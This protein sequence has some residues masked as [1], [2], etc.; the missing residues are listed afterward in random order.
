MLDYFS[1]PP[2]YTEY[3]QLP[4]GG[5]P[6]PPL[7]QENLKFFPFFQS[8]L[9]AVDGTHIAC[10]PSAAERSA[11]RNWKGLLT[12]NCLMACSFDLRF[13]YVLSGWEGSAADASVWQDARLSDFRIPPGRYYLADAGFGA[14]RE[15]LVPY[16]GVR[17][18]LEEFRRSN[19]AYV[20]FIFGFSSLPGLR[21]LSPRNKEELFNLR[22]ASARNVIERIFGIIK[23]R[24]K[25]LILPPSYSMKVQAQIPPAVC[26]IHNFIR[27]H[28][29][30]EVA[31]FHDTE[32]FEPELYGE[33]GTGPPGQAERDE[34]AVRRD[35]IASQMWVQYQ[36]VLRTH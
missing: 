29:P 9:G 23:A 13:I 12:Q 8:A 35:T 6:V 21:Y 11:A 4:I 2:F 3:V 10:C 26:S 16:R 33:L 27:V 15:L 32:Y 18:H 28:D 36:E 24:F 31:Q 1:S 7:I 17:Y 34:A 14:C 25:I 5:S 22:H 20:L 19:L 30:Q